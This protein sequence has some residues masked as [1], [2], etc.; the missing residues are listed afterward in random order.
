MESVM[1]W[2]FADGHKLAEG[3]LEV[4]VI[5]EDVL[6]VEDVLEAE[7]VLKA[8][9]TVLVLAVAFT[10][11]YGVVS[12]VHLFQKASRRG[13]ASNHDPAAMEGQV[14]PRP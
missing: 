13:V 1:I 10:K 9:E 11:L 8:E 3:T 14:C 7:D 6:R 4:E 12:R 5:V 2:P